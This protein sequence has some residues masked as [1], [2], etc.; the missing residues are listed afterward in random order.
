MK[1]LKPRFF[2][3]KTSQKFVETHTQRFCE[4][5]NLSQRE[6]SRKQTLTFHV[7]PLGLDYGEIYLEI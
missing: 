4:K 3:L 1:F 6:K 2:L 5:K 7:K